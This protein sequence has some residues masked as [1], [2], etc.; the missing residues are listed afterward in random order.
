MANR[1]RP[2]E[3]SLGGELGWVGVDPEFRGQHLS[4]IVCSAVQERYRREGYTQAYL[5]TDDYRLPAVKTYLELGWQPLIDSEVMK[6][7]WEKVCR[8][9]GKTVP[10]E[11]YASV[12]SNSNSIFTIN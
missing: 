10:E 5:R 12:L 8:K 7:R 1:V 4:S 9:L 3:E 2:G 6:K 11:A